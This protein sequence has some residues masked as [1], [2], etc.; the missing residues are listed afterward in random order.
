MYSLFSTCISIDCIDYV[1]GIGNIIQA[2]GHVLR[3]ASQY[4][5]QAT[6]NGQLL[7]LQLGILATGQHCCYKCVSYGMAKALGYLFRSFLFTCKSIFREAISS[8]MVCLVEPFR[9]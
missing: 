8:K 6:E 4:G 5:Q 3:V 2:L 1:T 7:T 9:S